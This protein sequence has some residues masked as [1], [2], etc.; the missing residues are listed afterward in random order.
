MQRGWLLCSV[1]DLGS[2]QAGK[3]LWRRKWQPTAV[4]LPGKL[5]RQRRLE[6]YSPWGC[7]ELD[8][9]EKMSML[10]HAKL[11]TTLSPMSSKQHLSF[12]IERV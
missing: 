12:T 4:L 5:H 10:T 9:T 2:V 7:K 6:G 3:I 1:G 11:E 8:M